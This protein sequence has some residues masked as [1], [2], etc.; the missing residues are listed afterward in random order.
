MKV[1]EKRG[2]TKTIRC[3]RCSNTVTP[4]M[5]L[6]EGCRGHSEMGTRFH[7]MNEIELATVETGAKECPHCGNWYEEFHMCRDTQE[8]ND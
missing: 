6:C 7:G 5:E 3:D 1:R 4:P 8:T 2:Q